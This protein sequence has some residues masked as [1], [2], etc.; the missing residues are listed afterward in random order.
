MN[1]RNYTIIIEFILVGFSEFKDLQLLLFIMFLLMYIITVLGNTSIILAYTLTTILNTPMYLF[2]THFSF[3]EIC[4]V[5]STLPKLLSN[6]AGDKTISFYNCAL[7]MYCFFLLVGTECCM[8][9]AMAYDR[10][11]A[12]CHP[13]LYSTIM[14]NTVCIQ[15]IGGSWLIAAVNSLI[16]TALTF[17]LPFCNDRTINHFFCDFPSVLKLACTDIWITETVS[18]ITGG[19]II[20][21]SLMLTIISYTLIILTILKTYSRSNK[22]FSTCTS[23]FMVIT[24]FYGSGMFMY[25]GPNTKY[26]KY[27]ERL[28]SLM[29]TIIAP[30]LNPFIYSLRNNEVKLAIRHSLSLIISVHKY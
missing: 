11:N 24:I 30:L 10:Y 22:A 17:S 23:H 2:L 25:L 16:H 19:S 7:Q 18:F 20:V 8:L 15:L 27:Q 29:Y 12:I 14:N 28:V 3:L 13:L 9:A 1:V 4:Y 26:A 5:T 21:G 6:L